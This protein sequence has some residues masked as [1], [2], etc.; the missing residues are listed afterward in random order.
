MQYREMT[1]VSSENYTKDIN[2][3]CEQNVYT[4][5]QKVVHTERPHF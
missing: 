2:T 4:T 3:G 5:L 1:A